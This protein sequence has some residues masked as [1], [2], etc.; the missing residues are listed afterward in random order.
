MAS[1]DPSPTHALP[2]RKS[3]EPATRP[4]AISR[5]QAIAAAINL[6]DQHGLRSLTIRKVAGQ[7]A[8]P[9]TALARLFRTRD[10]LLDG[11]VDAIVDQI[12]ADPDVQ[13]D[14]Q[15]W[16]EY[17]QRVAHAVRKAALAHP[18]AFPLLASRPP[19]APW[20]QPPLRSLR[21]METFLDAL[22]RFGFTDHAAVAAYRAFSSFL[23][24]H[25]LLEVSALGVDVTPVAEPNPQ[26]AK[27]GDLTDYPLLARLQPELADADPAD[28]FEEAL[29][30]LLDRLENRGRR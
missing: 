12:Y 24:G 8:V 30:S 20:L 13:P 19:A 25:L 17:L 27:P 28:E 23:L 4:A 11:I 1:S 29:E 3:E 26:A 6:V 15:K 16:Q 5:D 14:S 2:S 10:D 9:P 21:W 22:S 7:L 18:E